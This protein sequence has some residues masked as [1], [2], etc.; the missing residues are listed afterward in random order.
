SVDVFRG[1]DGQ[2]ALERVEQYLITI[3]DTGKGM[4]PDFMRE[5][6]FK[7]FHSTKG[8]TGMGIG[9]YQTKASLEAVG[10]EVFVESRVGEGTVFRILLPMAP[11]WILS[12]KIVCAR[13]DYGH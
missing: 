11:K 3:S 2:V 12:K 4:S 13:C 1:H 8:L 10:A 9:L 6:L 7:P 5:H